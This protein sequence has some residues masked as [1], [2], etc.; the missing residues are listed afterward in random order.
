MKVEASETYA[1]GSSYMAMMH[2]DVLIPRL[3][4]ACLVH[5]LIV[6]EVRK[7]L[8]MLKYVLNHGKVRGSIVKLT[9][10]ILEKQIVF[11]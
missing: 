5:L 4:C 9:E 11:I 2:V 7:S 10:E 8:A 3:I 6:P 1:N